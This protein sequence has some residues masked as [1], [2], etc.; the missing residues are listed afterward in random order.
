LHHLRFLIW[1]RLTFLLSGVLL[2]QNGGFERTLQV[3]GFVNLDISSGSGNITVRTGT[4]ESVHIVARIHAGNSWLDWFGMSATD[5]IHKLES[6]P[7]IE[8]QGNSIRVGHMDGWQLHNISIDYDVT[9]PSQTA[10]VSRTESGD[11]SISGLKLASAATAGSGSITIEN[12]DADVRLRTG[13]GDLKITS[14]KSLNAEIGSG[15]IRATHVAGEVVANTGSGSIEI[16]QVAPGNARIST[17]SGDVTL[18]GAKA[19]VRVETGSGEVHVEGEPTSDWHISTASGSIGLK[20]P[21][22]ASF[23]LDARTTSGS[24]KMDR[25]ITV[26]GLVSRDRL[27]G[28]VGNGGALLDAHTASGN[29]EI[30]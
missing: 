15:N 25:A 17:G 3:S 4:N 14:V 22:Q 23:D 19:A 11:Q 29:V 5:E 26:T 2:F 13:S 9:A 7:P 24:L 20:L 28:K 21:A 27:Q 30:D 6:N 1:T 16:E 18:H 12:I 10:L 8:Q